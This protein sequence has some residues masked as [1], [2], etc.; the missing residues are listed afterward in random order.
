LAIA[1]LYGSLEI[2]MCQ[3]G[4]DGESD[5]KALSQ[6]NDG[7]SSE[8]EGAIGMA[9]EKLIPVQKNIAIPISAL[10]PHDKNFREH[11]TEQIAM[12]KSSLERFGQVRSVVATPNNDGSYTIVAGH[13]VVE[14]AQKLIAA[15]PEYAERFGRIRCDI[16]DASWPQEQILGY[17]A[18]DNLISNHAQDDE[19]LLV[20]LLTEQQ[21]A[22]Y[23]LASLGTDDETL[24]Q[25]LEALGDEIIA[26]GEDTPVTFKEYDET[27]ADDLDTEMCAECGKLCVK[28]GKGKK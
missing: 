19:Q 6:G 2:A 17:L 21:S 12:L 26:D 24:R 1:Y 8:D 3:I 27:I 23:D 15:N 28:S 7:I 9:Q 10:Y 11:P 16:I 20:Q 5:T 25:M 22:G 18:A 14:A 13:G 4:T